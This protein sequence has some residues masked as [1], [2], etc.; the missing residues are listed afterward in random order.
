MFCLQL[1]NKAQ[2]IESQKQTICVGW[3]P[4][5][6]QQILCLTGFLWWSIQPSIRCLC[7]N[8]VRLLRILW[9]VQNF[10][11]RHDRRNK[12]VP[13][14]TNVDEL[15]NILFL[16]FIGHH[17]IRFSLS[18]RDEK[19]NLSQREKEQDVHYV[20]HSNVRGHKKS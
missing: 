11:I 4:E 10:S 13:F 18:Y 5:K 12:W 14:E 6:N 8:M 3:K 17:S 7:G 16:H 2:N 20:T 1:T 9:F 19:E 15:I